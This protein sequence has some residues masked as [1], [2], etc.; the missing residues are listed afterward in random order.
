MAHRVTAVSDSPLL[1]FEEGT[2]YFRTARAIPD[3]GLVPDDPTNKFVVIDPHSALEEIKTGH[4]FRGG[5]LMRL[6]SS[7]PGFQHAQV[8]VLA[9]KGRSGAVERVPLDISWLRGASE[10]Y[11]I[12]PDIRDFVFVNL[13]I[14][15]ADIP[16]RNMDCFSY[17]EL[18]RHSP[19]TG[20]LTYRTFVGK[21]THQNHKNQDP[22]KAKGVHFDASLA[23]AWVRPGQLG[24]ES[25][26][27]PIQVWKTRVMTGWDR[28]K[29]LSLA[30]SIEKRQRTGYSMGGLVDYAVCSVPT[31][32]AITTPRPCVHLANGGKGSVHSGYLVFEFCHGVNFIESSVLDE[33]PA[34]IDAWEPDRVWAPNNSAI[35]Y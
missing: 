1:P 30:T 17:P 4:Q 14:I 6:A 9:L 3:V 5:K 31:C 34:D 24:Y 13:P 18:T 28:S 12:S 21:P 19:I 29:D 27:D 20:M 15:T 33:E 25:Q 11:Q 26:A 7:D 23:Q 8:A 32:G 22:T 16:N 10:T 2:P 35:A